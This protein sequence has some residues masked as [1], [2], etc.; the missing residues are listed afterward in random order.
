MSRGQT[1]GVLLQALDAE[2]LGADR[3]FPRRRTVDDGVGGLHCKPPFRDTKRAFPIADPGRF[4]SSGL[5]R[6][7]EAAA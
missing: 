1:L 3:F 2:E 5:D 6:L 7:D 4:G